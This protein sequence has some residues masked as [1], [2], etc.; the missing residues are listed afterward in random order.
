[1]HE[2]AVACL[3]KDRDALLTFCNAPVKLV[4]AAKTW[5]RLKDGNQL[6]SGVT[7]RNGVAQIPA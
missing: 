3:L 1:M 7:F 4:M 6:V 5:R 2:K